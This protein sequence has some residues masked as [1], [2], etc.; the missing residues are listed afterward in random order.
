M[1]RCPRREQENNE[2]DTDCGGNGSNRPPSRITPHGGS[3]RLRKVGAERVPITS[4]GRVHDAT[5][6][7]F[8]GH[9]LEAQHGDVVQLAVARKAGE[10]SIRRPGYL[11][12][13]GTSCP[14]L[15]TAGHCYKCAA[16]PGAASQAGSAPVRTRSSAMSRSF[17]LVRCEAWVRRVNASSSLILCRSIKMPLACSIHARDIIAVRR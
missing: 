15:I 3:H 12:G 5:P 1:W 7:E 11:L 14:M 4:S 2:K 16:V 9:G 13:G 17:V 6:G 8:F 10:G